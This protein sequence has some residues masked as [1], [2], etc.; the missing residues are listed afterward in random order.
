[1]PIRR[2]TPE[3]LLERYRELRG[4]VEAKEFFRRPQHKK[5]PELRCAANFGR[6]YSFSFEPCWLHAADEDQQTDTDFYLEVGSA[7]HAFQITEVQAPDRRRGDEYRNGTPAEYTSEQYSMGETEGPIWVRE[8][9]LA[10][11]RHYGD[12]KNLN[13]LV[14]TNFPC[15]G[16]EYP[17][18]VAGTREPASEFQS[19]WLI[20]GDHICCIQR[21]PALGFAEG[22]VEIPGSLS[23]AGEP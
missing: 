13:L 7:K 19:V 12:V 15:W 22:W 16:M 17:E 4:S 5:T 20:N 11:L 3:E 14:Y 6:A 8:Q 18:Y 10:K 21:S 23:G 1:M 2:Y 9:I